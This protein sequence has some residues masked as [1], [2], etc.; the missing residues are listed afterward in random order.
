LSCGSSGPPSKALISHHRRDTNSG[1]DVSLWYRSPLNS[2]PITNACHGVLLFRVD[3]IPQNRYFLWLQ[4]TRRSASLARS[5]QVHRYGAMRCVQG[6]D[7]QGLEGDHKKNT[8]PRNGLDRIKQQLS[9][10]SIVVMLD[11]VGNSQ[12]PHPSSRKLAAR[13]KNNGKTG[14]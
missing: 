1:L 5:S 14:P 11:D 2:G 10:Q 7:K 9:R 6:V 8:R 4:A 13:P 12:E 3:D